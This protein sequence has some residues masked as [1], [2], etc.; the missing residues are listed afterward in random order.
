MNQNPVIGNTGGL[1][2]IRKDTFLKFG[3]FNE[4]YISCLEDVELNL[5]LK[6][7]TMIEMVYLPHAK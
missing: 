7:I 1:M 2:L 6:L 4:N 3:M 5:K